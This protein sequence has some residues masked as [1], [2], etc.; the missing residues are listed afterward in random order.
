MNP[1]KLILFINTTYWP[2]EE[3]V[4][5]FNTGRAECRKDF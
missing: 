3:K 5:T 2:G 4:E 1:V